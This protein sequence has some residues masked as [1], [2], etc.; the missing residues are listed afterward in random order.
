MHWTVEHDMVVRRFGAGR[1]IVWI[2]GLGEQSASFDA[3]ATRLAGFA[4][5]L[6][7]LPGYGRSPWRAPES[8]EETTDR[9]TRW[10]PADAIVI[11]HSLGGV[12]AQLVAERTKLAAVINVDGNLSRGDCTYSAQAI[13]YTADDFAA[14]GFDVMRD[15]IY[16]L[17]IADPALRG[18]YAAM[19]MASPHQFHRHAVELVE[20]SSSET[21]AARLAALAT[22]VLFIAGSPTGGICARSRALIAEHRIRCVTID[23]SGHWPFVDQPD[24]FMKAM[25]EFLTD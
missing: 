8:I 1:T 25:Y 6:V 24:A 23:E 22:P 15:E 16:K 10:M 9:L 14:R 4:H 12:F 20:L 17:G 2:H 21:L 19:R 18:Y 5:V 11:G 7:D 13:P 3:V